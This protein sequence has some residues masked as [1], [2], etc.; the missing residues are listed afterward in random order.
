MKQ[1]ELAV[2]Q[3]ANDNEVQIESQQIMEE[4]NENENGDQIQSVIIEE[5]EEKKEDSKSPKKKKKR[6]KTMSGM[7]IRSIFAERIKRPM[8]CQYGELVVVDTRGGKVVVNTVGDPKKGTL[9][10]MWCHAIM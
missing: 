4:Q 9:C 6:K 5:E 10:R 2:V 1:S 7:R 3:S 8:K